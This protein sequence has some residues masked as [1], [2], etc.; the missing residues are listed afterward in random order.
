[1]MSI[2][3][4]KQKL[5]LKESQ[6]TPNDRE[7]FPR[8]LRSYCSF[9]GVDREIDSIP[10]SLEQAISFSRSLKAS[11][12]QAWKRLQ[13]V[14]ALDCYQRLMGPERV[15]LTEMKVTLRMAAAQ[16]RNGP[17]GDGR[18]DPGEELLPQVLREMIVELRLQGYAYDTEKAY[19]GWIK[20]FI[21][22]CG[23]ENLAD[24]EETRI[25]AYVSDLAVS[26]NVAASTQKQALSALLFLYE[27]VFGKELGFLD[28]H[29]SDKAQRLPVVFSQQEVAR[30]APLFSGQNRLMFDL[31]YGAGLRHKECRRLRI[32][33][34]E[35]DQLQIFVRDG[36]GEKD[37][38]TVLPQVAIPALQRQIETV[39]LRHQADLQEGFGEVYLPYA[40]AKKL[41]NAA[42]EFSWQYLFPSRQRSKDKRSGKWRRHYLSANRFCGE[43]KKALKAAKIDKHAV[44]HTLRHSF[45]THLLEN[46]SDIRTVQELMGHEDVATTMIYLHVKANPGLAV[47]SPLDRLDQG[48]RRKGMVDE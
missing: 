10:V 43:F 31:M 45:A 41:P 21:T 11:G 46:G 22:F 25:R 42:R 15:D 6:V 14:M 34:I 1:M 18:I 33:D 9:H 28:I 7:W 36:K 47:I 3:Q 39:R 29:R 13:F 4:F 27:R 5:H 40:L 19:L 26:G 48:K 17:P 44:P 24:V 12:S 16:E 32:K 8:W 37:R 23:T 30:L 35:F 38:V 20:R 2:Q